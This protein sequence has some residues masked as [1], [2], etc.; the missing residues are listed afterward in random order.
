MDYTKFADDQ[1]KS[2]STRR[3]YNA[4]YNAHLKQ[5][6]NEDGVIL[7][8]K[9][10]DIL[11]YV[12][13]SNRRQSTKNTIIVLLGRLMIYGGV[14]PKDVTIVKQRFSNDSDETTN[15][16]KEKI[17]KFIERQIRNG[18]MK[19]FVINTLLFNH[20]LTETELKSLIIST[21]I[22]TS[23]DSGIFIRPNYISIQS[24]F[25]D[26][27]KKYGM[28]K[29]RLFSKRFLDYLK[30]NVGKTI[31]E[32]NDVLTDFTYNGFTKQ[33]YED[34]FTSDLTGTRLIEYNKYK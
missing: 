22:P 29:M 25:Y 26:G 14:D 9:I 1:L 10:P 11:D 24:K 33:Q 16:T 4:T 31:M 5:F 17:E 6:E 28:K 21:D 20:D 2:K 19:S 34:A 13:Y 8:D 27:F 30:D 18:E 23:R 15:E 12:K 32:D 7:Q 3:S